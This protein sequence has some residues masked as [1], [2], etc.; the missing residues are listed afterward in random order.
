VT[1]CSAGRCERNFWVVA[2]S[3]QRYKSNIALPRLSK[4]STTQKL[5]PAAQPEPLESVGFALRNRPE[6]SRE[7]YAGV[8]AEHESLLYE[9]A[10]RLLVELRREH[11]DCWW[12][13]ELR[14]DA[15]LCFLS[16]LRDT[17]ALIAAVSDG[18]PP[19]VHVT[20]RSELAEDWDLPPTIVRRLTEG[21]QAGYGTF[22]V[23][24]M[25][26][27]G[28][29]L[30]AVDVEAED[31]RDPK[32][33]LRLYL[34]DD[35]T[36]VA[37]F[38]QSERRIGR[39][40]FTLSTTPWSYLRLDITPAPRG[41][42]SPLEQIDWLF[43]EHGPHVVR[44]LWE[45]FLSADRATKLMMIALGGSDAAELEDAVGSIRLCS[46]GTVSASVMNHA[47]FEEFTSGYGRIAAVLTKPAP[48]GWLPVVVQL[49]NWAGIRWLRIAASVGS[50]VPRPMTERR[51]ADLRA[52]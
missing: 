29:S 11:G 51:R 44:W 3:R 38:A 8:L 1:W 17:A 36:V 5:E 18:D 32:T 41:V 27:E 2:H 14:S 28:V 16:G 13:K 33:R 42:A 6:F 49:R 7:E 12:D 30:R 39:Y 9:V 21:P 15:V 23:V 45:Y 37:P 34:P 43:A 40:L 46:D 31:D 20:S 35:D 24:V 25:T 22:H 19:W 47:L 48:A 26:L 10:D 52:V 4:R 50:E